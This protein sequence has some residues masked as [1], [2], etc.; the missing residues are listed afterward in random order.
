MWETYAYVYHSGV[1]GETINENKVGLIENVLLSST[2]ASE[3][4]N[5]VSKLDLVAI[6][7][8]D[9]V[10]LLYAGY[11]TTYYGGL[12]GTV[13]SVRF[14]GNW[15][16]KINS[17]KMY[18]PSKA[19]AQGVTKWW[20]AAN[21]ATED[22]RNITPTVGTVYYIK[23]VTNRYLTARIQ[24]IYNK[25]ANNQVEKVYLL[26]VVDDQNYQSVGFVDFGA[27]TLTGSFVFQDEHGEQTVTKPNDFTG[28]SRGFIGWRDTNF[29]VDEDGFLVN[30]DFEFTA[31]PY[32]VTYDGVTVLGNDRTFIYSYDG[33]NPATIIEDK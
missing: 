3:Q 27:A 33:S 20:K 7:R 10:Y 31:Y 19:Y 9:S 12:T 30:T 4:S 2:R 13:G 11:S 17:G 25:K 23:Q 32:W 5:V 6:T 14:E 28:V 21:M 22:G 18:D 15:D 26:T 24:Y 16:A 29:E 1:E 8:A